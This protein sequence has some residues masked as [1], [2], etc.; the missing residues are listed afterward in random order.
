MGEVTPFRAARNAPQLKNPGTK[1]EE[2]LAAARRKLLETG[3]R[4]RLIH[5]P[6][7]TKRARA[8]DL[9]G[10]GS[11]HVFELLVRNGKALRF[12]P[13]EE[14]AA[15]QKEAVRR[16]LPRLVGSSARCWA[17]LQTA[18]LP[19]P[20]D[21]QLRGMRRDACA[22]EEERGVNVLFLALGFLRWYE[23][24]KSDV[25]R[26]A[27][28]IL[29]PVSIV[30]DDKRAVFDLRL[31][32]EEIAANQALQERLRG[33]FGLILP[34]VPE[35][36]EWLPSAYF[37]EVSNAVASKP[38][39][40]I[41]ANAMELGFYSYSKILLVKDLD[42]AHWPGNRLITHP[43]LC[44]LLGEGFG[45]EPPVLPEEARLDEQLSP[46]DLVHIVDADASQTRVIETVRAGRNLA[47]QG[48][49]G[50]G[51]SQTI[52]NIIAAAVHDGR[53]VLFVAEKMAALNVVRERLRNAGLEDIY[54]ELH[55]QTV[56]SRMVAERLDRTLQSTSLL[57]P[58][59]DTTEALSAA[60][61]R[62]NS[63][64]GRL[65]TEIGGTGM[66]PYQALA[67]QIAA[68][69]RG[70][71]PDPELVEEAAA[72]SGEAFA[73]KARL[74]TQLASLTAGAGPLFA[75]P[76]RGVQRLD[77][78]PADFLR[79]VPKLRALA[80]EAHSLA[81]YA[82]RISEYFGLTPGAGLS[83]IKTL[84]S[85]FRAILRLPPGSESL[86]AAIAS[87]PSPRRI[88]E[89]AA[90]G[91]RWRAQQEPFLHTFHP[92]AWTAPVANLRAPLAKGT[93]RWL[94]R[95]GKPYREGGR[96]LASLLSVPLPHQPAERLALVDALIT[97]QALR[98]EFAKQAG[99][100]TSLLGDPWQAS[101]PV[102][103]LIQN[104]SGTVSAIAGIDPQVDGARLI[105]IA[106]DGSA[107]VHCDQLE[108]SLN[109]VAAL[110]ADAVKVL[111]LDISAAFEAIGI[112]S[113]DLH[114]LSARARHWVENSRRFEEWARLAKADR[115]LRG[116]GP[117]GIADGLA[118]G[119]LR[120]SEACLEL[121]TAFAE[122][123]WKK[124]IAADPELA[125]FDGDRHNELVRRFAALEEE[126]RRTAAWRV[127]ARH[128]ASITCGAQGEMGVIRGEIG[129]KRA[130]MPLRKL[131]MAAGRTIQ[132]IKPVFLMSPVSAAQFL[133]PGSVEFDLLIIDEAS[134]L[135]PED[136]LGLI[137][138][139][140]QAV[141]VGDKK[142]L[143]PTSFFDRLTADDSGS[144]DG[145]GSAL[146]EGGC[147]ASITD[148]ESI[149]SLCE[150]RGFESQMLRWHYRSRHPSLIEVSNA[151][152]YRRLILPPAPEAARLGKGLILRRVAGAYDRGGKRIN[153]AEAEAIADAVAAHAR[154]PEGLSLGVV[155]FSTPQRD[156]ISD[157][158]ERRRRHDPLLDA[159]L[160]EG[161][162]EDVFV[163]NLENVQ[164]DERDVILISI[165]YGPRLAGEP[166]DSMAFGPVSAEGGERRLNV[167]F[168]RARVRC[169]VFASFS[170]GDIDLER[171]TG[172]GPRVLKRFLQYAE[173]G[174][175]PER[176][177][178]GGS[179]DS[180][181]E[182][183]VAEAVRS[184]GYEVDSQVGS[185]GF[186]I[187]L[188]V[189]DPAKAGRYILAIECDGAT[190]HSAL[191][192]RERDRLR[193]QVL[194]G[195][196]WR[197]YR[198]WSTD[199]FY[200][201]AEELEKLRLVLEAARE[202]G[203]D[204]PALPS[205]SAAAGGV[206][207]QNKNRRLR[208]SPAAARKSV[209]EVK[210]MPGSSGGAPGQKCAVK[211]SA[212]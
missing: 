181:F 55:S 104:V 60:R 147:A 21:K 184:F 119:Q 203:E 47:V 69:G 178:A 101:R 126:A 199:W 51:K 197:F 194:E 137:A 39:W 130:H 143:P 102:F 135:R 64:A 52:T 210:T 141:V 148:M 8:L 169:E 155:T 111:A 202:E 174:I 97:S 79:L 2:L 173:S 89:A 13:A 4:N 19:G 128:Q 188:A 35:R 83:G 57:P 190:Y 96:L 24:E 117:A 91:A 10:N 48:P 201:R 134:Q 113:I 44:G 71:H 212:G 87:S 15:P 112:P 72:W 30:H 80:D 14:A 45:A 66:T 27:P 92:A 54:L 208:K 157:T 34:D 189:R 209:P 166:L 131:M 187:D 9:S 26:H 132:K 192:A 100:L 116:E 32:E 23:D 12:L 152:F 145:A 42:P 158:L 94:A 139:C 153:Q 43:I 7:G 180:P 171:A 75:H 129:R 191:W 81:A 154:R 17:G 108:A 70:F 176:P 160:S 115:E 6:R 28:L 136:A 40:S 16:K 109:N 41:D 78:Q 121:E 151:E 193:Q 170:P 114:V 164:G 37:S 165:A 20:L 206:P 167:L 123:C 182:A 122:A 25:P 61:A 76:F 33:D 127:R 195:L 3:T 67:A 95:L 11:D 118:S 105:A 93:S 58:V 120:A 106:R 161:E 68:A 18:L 162:P 144:G 196:G 29:I 175:L 103:Q 98:C 1:I 5:T 36:G 159:F 77:L 186:K 82:A 63:V 73:A 133:P 59:N 207:G 125:A 86:A 156:L 205:H 85:A 138:R 211:R 204:P 107:R 183:A 65:H 49:P 62:L 172:E 84:I 124:A 150:A 46:A 200:R 149:L 140:R 99:A 90:L 31:R 198:I 177:P 22:A 142:Q 74:V 185:A 88:A 110:L 53:T 38:R 168:T 146:A 179:F 163:K 56:S 50:T